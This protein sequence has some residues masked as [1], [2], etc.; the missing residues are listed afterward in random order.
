MA[1]RAARKEPA[2]STP[3]AATTARDEVRQ[4]APTLIEMRKVFEEVR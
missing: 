2:V 3:R 4:V 1:R